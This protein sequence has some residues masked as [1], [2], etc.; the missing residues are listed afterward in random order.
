MNQPTRVPPPG[1][2]HGPHHHPHY[3]LPLFLIYRELRLARGASDPVD[4][5]GDMCL[6]I[7]RLGLVIGGVWAVIAGMQDLSSFHWRGGTLAVGWGLVALLV[8]AMTFGVRRL[9]WRVAAAV[10]VLWAFALLAPNSEAGDAASPAAASGLQAY[11]APSYVPP[12]TETAPAAPAPAPRTMPVAPPQPA[13][14]AIASRV[15][16]A[17]LTVS[18][19]V[20]EI[21]AGYHLTVTR[22]RLHEQADGSFTA[23][24]VVTNSQPVPVRAVLILSVV[25]SPNEIAGGFTDAGCIPAHGSRPISWHGLRAAGAQP[26]DG[27]AVTDSASVVGCGSS[28]AQ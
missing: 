10:A 1:A 7:F 15:Y 17:D 12:V 23:A 3:G 8:L 22:L 5:L 14:A 16:R 9:G 25:N 28:P 20:D 26:Y 21:R 4:D 13:A 24:G 27:A 6:W 18:A 19:T 2:H 11:E